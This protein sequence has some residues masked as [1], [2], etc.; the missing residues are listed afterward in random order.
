MRDLSSADRYRMFVLNSCTNIGGLAQN[1]GLQEYFKRDYNEPR[2]SGETF[3]F[4]EKM[5]LPEIFVRLMDNRN[6]KLQ[7]DSIKCKMIH[8]DYYPQEARTSYDV[9]LDDRRNLCQELH[10]KLCKYL[11]IPETRVR[12]VNFRDTK[13]DFDMFTY[14]DTKDGCLYVNTEIDY[15]NCEPT[16]LAE[17]IM[18]GT[19]VHEIHYKLKKNLFKMDEVDAKERY[20]LVSALMKEFAINNLREEDYSTMAKCFDYNDGYSSSQLYA[21]FNTYN[22]IYSMLKKHGIEDMPEFKTFCDSRQEFLTQLIGT[23]EEDDNYEEF[24][25]EFDYNEDDESVEASLDIDTQDA[26]IEQSLDYDFDLLYSIETSEINK[27][28]LGMFS[29]FFLEELNSSADEYYEFFGMGFRDSSFKEE[30]ELFKEDNF[31]ADGFAE[32][33]EIN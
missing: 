19:F 24:N 2:N 4:Y 21:I 1:H 15:S 18:Q 20:L 30:F 25:L 26:I 17:R 6:F 3:T 31:V 22:Y 16:E 5:Y 23:Q 11:G 7:P 9:Y 33:D 14:Y 13:Y 28:T 27:D 10:N 32:E 8:T 12:F 29:D